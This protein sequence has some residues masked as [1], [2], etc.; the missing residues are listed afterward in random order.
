GDDLG[1]RVQRLDRALRRIG[2]PLAER[3]RRVRDLALQVR[4]VDLVVVDDSEAADT[5]GG[6]IEARGRAEAARADQQDA[7]L[8][9]L[10]L[11]FDADLGDQDVPAVARA[12]QPAH[13]DPRGDRKST[14]L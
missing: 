7:R 3:L 8:E 5:G 12:L 6:E 11:P 13:P 4:R 9:Q 10:Q 1:V 14:R 2:L